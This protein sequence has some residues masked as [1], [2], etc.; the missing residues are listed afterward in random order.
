M[1]FMPKTDFDGDGDYM[2]CYLSRRS[3][4]VYCAGA[5][6]PIG[7]TCSGAGPMTC[8]RKA[9]MADTSIRRYSTWQYL[10][11]TLCRA[12]RPDLC[13]QDHCKVV[14]PSSFS[15]TSCLHIALLLAAV[16]LLRQHKA[17]NSCTDQ[18][19]WPRVSVSLCKLDTSVAAAVDRTRLCTR[20][21]DTFA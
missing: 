5:Q 2:I 10:L 15:K 11:C 14:M 6:T 18:Q 8:M 3:E 16:C 7:Y 1:T 12:T 20:L 21:C 19:P 13:D 4:E 9:C 17:E